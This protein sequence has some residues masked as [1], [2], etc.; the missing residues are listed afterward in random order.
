LVDPEGEQEAG[1]WDAVWRAPLVRNLETMVGQ[2]WQVGRA[3]KM[4]TIP[5]LDRFP[6]QAIWDRSANEFL[7]VE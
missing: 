1:H 5:S 3:V 4:A 2:F 6:A 7:Y